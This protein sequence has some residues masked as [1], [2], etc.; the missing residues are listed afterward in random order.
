L[1]EAAVRA[2]LAGGPARPPEGDRASRP[3]ADEH[4]FRY[5]LWLFS[6]VNLLQG[7]GYFLFSGVA[8]IGDWVG[9]VHGL[10]PTWFWRVALAV[11]GGLSYWLSVWL[12]LVQLGP[13]IGADPT[14]RL[15]RAYCMTL[16][17]YFTGAALYVGAGLINPRGML[18]VAFSAAA[19][20][21]GGTC[22]FAWGPQ[23]LRGDFIPPSAEG[24]NP[25]ARSWP[26]I[27]SAIAVAIPFVVVLG[28]GISL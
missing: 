7:T 27:V 3:E 20:S 15:R 6:T 25:I 16:I 23:M 18:L 9:V 14:D 24:P 4:L 5:A 26:W 13:F 17:P 8:G 12:A 10:N 11:V 19:S 22:G 1:P 28:P 21:L 2:H